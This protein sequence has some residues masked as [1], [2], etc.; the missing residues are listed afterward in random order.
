MREPSMFVTP[1]INQLSVGQNPKKGRKK[2][3]TVTIASRN[4]GTHTAVHKLFPPEQTV[5]SPSH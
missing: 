3:P 4:S 1:G 2:M 5:C